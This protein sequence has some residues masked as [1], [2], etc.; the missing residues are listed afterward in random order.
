VNSA[1]ARESEKPRNL[2]PLHR[3]SE[4][5]FPARMAVTK[6]L[7]NLAFLGRTVPCPLTGRVQTQE[8]LGGE[9]A[10]D[11]GSVAKKAYKTQ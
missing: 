10:S 7:R 5:Y 8:Q 2:H 1:E 3:N 6:D 9:A 11:A 4:F